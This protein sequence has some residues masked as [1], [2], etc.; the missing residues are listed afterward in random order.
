[1]FGYLYE[2]KI[3]QQHLLKFQMFDHELHKINL[4]IALPGNQ[5]DITGEMHIDRF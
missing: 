5:L 3:I 4:L 1:M 2:Q